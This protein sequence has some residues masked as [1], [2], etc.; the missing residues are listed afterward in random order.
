RSAQLNKEDKMRRL[1]GITLLVFGIL[2]AT[3]LA[4]PERTHANARCSY[5][6]WQACGS[7]QGGY[8]CQPSIG[9]KEECVRTQPDS[10]GC[11]QNCTNQLFCS[12]AA[13]TQ[14]CNVPP[15]AKAVRRLL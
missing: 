6:F 3:I 5:C 12:S 7:G 13:S 1:F 14:A 2:W 4:S 10:A 9:V 15:T 8:Y 11:Y